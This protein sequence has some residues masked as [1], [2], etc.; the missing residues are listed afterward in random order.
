[1][2][3][4]QNGDPDHRR[5]VHFVDRRFRRFYELACALQRPPPGGSKAAGGGSGARR[6]KELARA[7]AHLPSRRTLRRSNKA[8]FLVGRAGGLAR[9]LVEGVAAVQRGRGAGGKRRDAAAKALD[10]RVAEFLGL[11]D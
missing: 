7:V 4:P 9:F 2:P 1:M 5:C 3:L 11:I 8:R 6:R 10:V